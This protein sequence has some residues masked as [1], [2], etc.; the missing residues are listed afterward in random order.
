MKVFDQQYHIS[1]IKSNQLTGHKSNLNDN[2]K[3]TPQ[4]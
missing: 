3:G 2:N 4:S 1:R